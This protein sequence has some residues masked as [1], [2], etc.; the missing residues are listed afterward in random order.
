MNEVYK[1]TTSRRCRDVVFF[2]DA[3]EQNKDTQNR[4]IEALLRGKSSE[5]LHVELEG[6]SLEI[7]DY[8]G[9]TPLQA[10]IRGLNL[11]IVKHI[12]EKLGD[13]AAQEWKK[14]DFNAEKENI[15]KAMLMNSIFNPKGEKSS[16]WSVSK[17]SSGFFNRGS[18]SQPEKRDHILFAQA[19]F[20]DPNN[21]A[22]EVTKAK[23]KELNKLIQHV[24]YK[25][26]NQLNTTY[27]FGG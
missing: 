1:V 10:A 3:I 16:I 4:Y 26:G 13:K 15:Q 9:I 6:A 21:L 2:P 19:S 12:E 27:K 20:Q 7:P 22:Q 5:A 14:I 18:V 11:K 25:A 8:R 23:R 17:M 24:E